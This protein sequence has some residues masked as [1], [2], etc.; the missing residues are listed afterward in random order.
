MKPY[1]K[2]LNIEGQYRLLARACRICFRGKTAI[3]AEST[4]E[5]W[6]GKLHAPFILALDSECYTWGLKVFF[7]IK[8]YYVVHSFAIIL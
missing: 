2:E 7:R 6:I 3:N 8:G 5:K 4:L 1:I